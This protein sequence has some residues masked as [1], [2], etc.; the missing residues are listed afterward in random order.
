MR[1][2]V[3][4]AGIPAVLLDR[5]SSAGLW[6]GQT[7]ED[8]MGIAYADADAFLRGLPVGQE[9]LAAIEGRIAGYN[10]KGNVLDYPEG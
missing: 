1:A 9:A 2:L 10:G 8:E 5:P 7:D 4:W 3:R 6:E